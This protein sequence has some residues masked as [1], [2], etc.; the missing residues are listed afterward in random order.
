MVEQSKDLNSIGVLGGLKYNTQKVGKPTLT[1]QPKCHPLPQH[2][3]VI[4]SDLEA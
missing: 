4:R 2:I 3:H 1:D